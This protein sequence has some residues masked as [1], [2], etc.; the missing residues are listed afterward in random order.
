MS[1][2]VVI[3]W[4]DPGEVSGRFMD[5][6]LRVMYQSQEAVSTGAAAEYSV[7]GHVRIESGPRIAAARNNLVRSFL[8]KEEWSDVE[9]LLM[10]DAD[11]TFDG[12]IIET[13]L[14]TA[15]RE[16]GTIARPVISGLYFGGGHEAIFPV[17][18]RIV[19]PTTNDGKPLTVVT[20]F[21]AGD[22]V[23]VDAVGCGCLLVHRSVYEQMRLEE[24]EPYPWFAETIYNGQEFG[25]DWSFCMKVRRRDWPIYCDTGVQ[26]GHVKSVVMDEKM[27]RSG[28]VGLRQVA[29]PTGGEKKPLSLVTPLSKVTPMNREARRQ[30]QRSKR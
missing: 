4:A 16:D 21:T 13:L 14:R 23:A 11:V 26:M 30:A 6:V 24:P 9:W 19:D 7:V 1:E 25:E 28:Q 17:M 8:D 5:S 2:R 27:W 15:R 29:P 10:L 22:V 18:F 20:D 3:C 12:S